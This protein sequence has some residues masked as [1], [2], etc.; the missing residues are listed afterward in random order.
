MYREQTGKAIS[1]VEDFFALLAKYERAAVEVF[2]EYLDHLA[3]G[4]RNI[5][6]IQ[7][8]QYVIIGGILSMFEEFFLEP[9]QEKVFVENSFYDRSDVRIMCSTL[10]KDASILGAS[11]LPFERIF[12][13]HEIQSKVA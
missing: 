8:P 2:D 10:K 13:L 11:L 4:I 6:L 12:S 5:I 1:S 7:D 3:T 9:L